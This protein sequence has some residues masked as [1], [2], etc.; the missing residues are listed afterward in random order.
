MRGCRFSR[1]LL[2]RVNE[3]GEETALGW[4]VLCSS[5]CCCRVRMIGLAAA[6]IVSEMCAFCGLN[7]V[8]DS[9][10]VDDDDVE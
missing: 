5:C 9:S 8:S 4:G 6:V 7:E 1:G 3:V 2:R 10:E